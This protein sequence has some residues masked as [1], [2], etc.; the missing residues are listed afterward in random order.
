MTT[1]TAPTTQIGNIATSLDAMA[2]RLPHQPAV[3]YPHSRDSSGRVSYVH[4][5]Y[6]QLL[7]ASSQ[8]AHGLAHYGITRGTR[9]VLMVTPS[10]EFFALTFALFRAGIVP[11]MVDPG[12]GRKNLKICLA[13]AEPQAFIGI[14]KAHLGRMLLG[15][16]RDTIKINITTGKRGFA[17]IITLDQVMQA[18]ASQGHFEAADTRTDETAAILFTSGSTGISKGVIYNHGNFLAQVE[19][20]RDTY[21]IQP[22]EI[23]LPTFPPFSLF[24]PA[25]GMTTI[26][27]DMD[28]T[29][30][31]DVDPIKLIEAIENF[32]VTNMFGSPALLNRLGRYVAEHDIRFPTL[33]RII[34]AGAPVPAE[35]LQRFDNALNPDVQIFTPYGA[36][37]TMPVANIGSHEIL[38]E[39]AEKTAQ[40]AGVCI[41][42][43]AE[44]VSAAIIAIDD[45][46]IENWDSSLELPPDEIG[47]IVIKS[48]TVTQ[49]YYN[50]PQATQLAKIKDAD[51][52]IRHRMGDLGYFDQQ[53]RLW[54]C[55]RK[56]HRVVTSSGTLFTIPC[57]RVFNTHPAV[58]RTALVGV[59]RNGAVEPVLCVELEANLTNPNHQQIERELLAIGAQHPHTQPVKTMLFHPAFPVDIRHN[60]KIFREKLGP[61]AA[62]ELAR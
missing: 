36:T 45:G 13:E 15:W 48:P 12:I 33:R 6:S 11:V 39:T 52:Q 22:G 28:F 62:K 43:P 18:G 34:S 59:E 60:S 37:E 61:W 42:R 35:V 55:G 10:L 31:A 5:T 8:I 4:Y 25:L 7:R 53:G 38:N 58:Y 2:A 1:Q 27:P 17:G 29:R 30:P 23:D 51:G 50:R 24:D 46:P 3:I 49:G 54:F 40:G 19:M 47:E 21:G 14:P 57:E 32:G 26:I 9:T 41:G 16:A 44:R 20:I 56:T